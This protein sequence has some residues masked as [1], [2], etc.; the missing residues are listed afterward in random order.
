MQ[1][2]TQAKCLSG[3]FGGLFFRVV[4]RNL[5]RESSGPFLLATQHHRPKVAGLEDSDVLA[6]A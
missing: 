3:V 5:R 4:L 6:E 2:L 1:L